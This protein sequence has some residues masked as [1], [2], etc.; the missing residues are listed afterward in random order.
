MSLDAKARSHARPSRGGRAI[1]VRDVAR[2]ANVSVATVSRALNGKATVAANLRAEVERVSRELGYT[3]HAAARALATQRPSTFGAIVPTLHE[4]NFSAGVNALQRRLNAAGYTLLLGSTN[5]D[6][7]EEVRQVGA[8]LSQGIAG[9]ML[10]GGR[11]RP[12]VYDLLASRGV[13]FVN[14]WVLD[15]EHPSV[16]FDNHAIGRTLVDYLHD[17]GHRDFG[18]IAQQGERSDRASLRV[19]GMRAALKEKGGDGPQVHLIGHSHDIVAGQHAFRTLMESGRRPTAVI[20]GTDTL[21]FGALV[22][23]RAMHI[24]VPE[25]VSVTGINDVMF[26]AHLTPPLT[27]IRLPAEQVGEEAADL[28]LASIRGGA[29]ARSTEI[30]Y[31]LVIRGSTAAR[32]E[33][34]GARR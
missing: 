14:T 16:G 20:C 6:P 32:P 5:Y 29:V 31:K 2:A 23:A 4:T 21:A 3:P 18:V 28:L 19:A 11:H 24:R 12:A 8:L 15:D 27:T 25:D 30:A 22:Q 1:T 7:E 9:L 26:A 33:G 17:I 34:G 13:P 10:V